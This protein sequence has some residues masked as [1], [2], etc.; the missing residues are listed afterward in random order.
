MRLPAK[1]P[2]IA[3]FVLTAA[4]ILSG[5]LFLLFAS[6]KSASSKAVITTPDKTIEVDLGENT[7]FPLTS[8]GYD[9]VIAVADGEIYVKESNC[10]DKICKATGAVGKRPGSIVCMP[11]KLIITCKA[12][13]ENGADVII[14]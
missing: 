9:F 10:H 1:K 7:S 14:P 5:V 11:A 2:T 3:D 4:I 8:N 12:G 6:G 13:G